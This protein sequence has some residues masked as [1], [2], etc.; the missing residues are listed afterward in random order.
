MSCESFCNARLTCRDMN[1]IIER[2][3]SIIGPLLQKVFVGQHSAF[4][5]Y[6]RRCVFK[7]LIDLTT[8][9]RSRAHYHL[10]LAVFSR[11]S[12]ETSLLN[13]LVEGVRHRHTQFRMIIFYGVDFTCTEDSL[14]EFL[15]VTGVASLAIIDSAFPGNLK[16]FLA[17]HKFQYGQLDV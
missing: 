13:R 1:A 3:S 16:G 11:V 6:P 14:A 4:T 12:F 9:L 17:R 10:Q 7:D 5:Q 8:Y 15:K 2:H